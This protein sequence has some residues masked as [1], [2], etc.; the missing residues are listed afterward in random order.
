MI[1]IQE[2]L[3]NFNKIKNILNSDNILEEIR[4]NIISSDIIEN[5]N[6]FNFCKKNIDNNYD[7]NI[8]YK[9][10]INLNNYLDPYILDNINYSNNNTDEIIEEDTEK[11]NQLFDK[12]II[13]IE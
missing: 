13:M 2:K 10:L 3:N 1:N 9:N 8:E 11:I 12:L 5:N 7:E 4:K 6:I